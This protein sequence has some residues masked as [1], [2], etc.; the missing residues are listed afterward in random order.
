MMTY[1]MIKIQK[2]L[3]RLNSKEDFEDIHMQKA[4]E[5]CE[6]LELPHDIAI[7]S[8]ELWSKLLMRVPRT[9]IR[10]L[11]DCIYVVAHMTGNRRSIN[12]LA[13][14]AKKVTGFR[15]RAML[16]DSRREGTRWVETKWV[17]PI[18]LEVLPDEDALNTLL[19]EYPSSKEEGDS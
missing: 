11:C 13:D 3:F 8:F 1:G 18:I 17:H 14:V 16:K 2:E 9:P 15:V 10:L 4:E 5:I 7:I 19:S 12:S 6:K